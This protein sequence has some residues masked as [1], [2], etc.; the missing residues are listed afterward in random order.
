MWRT[1]KRQQQQQQEPIKMNGHRRVYCERCECSKNRIKAANHR[2]GSY[3]ATIG[4]IMILLGA[5]ASM[6]CILYFFKQQDD[7]DREQHQ[8]TD[9]PSQLL[10]DLWPDDS[11][12][13]ATK[14]IQGMERAKYLYFNAIKLE[15]QRMIMRDGTGRADYA[16]ANAGAR[17][18]SIG[19]TQLFWHKQR[20]VIVQTMLD[21]IGLDKQAVERNGPWNVL[22][23]SM[24]PGD[25]FA[26][27]GAGEIVIRLV[28]SIYIDAITI[29]HILLEISPDGSIQNAPKRFH[30]HGITDDWNDIYLGTFEY[31]IGLRQPIQMFTIQQNVNKKFPMA[32]IKFVSNHGHP[33]HTCVYRIRVHGNVNEGNACHE[34]NCN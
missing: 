23:P 6:L 17:I 10:D 8:P 30:I 24:Q 25:C 4:I 9:K 7:S 19:D 16:L 11:P 15:L 18:I 5:V 28:R 13:S 26:F 3:K 34:N 22:Q 33:S 21:F 31:D 20:N 32:R 12:E 27:I 2:Q 29:E 1:V 14:I